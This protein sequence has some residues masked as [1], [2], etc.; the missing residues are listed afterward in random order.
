MHEAGLDNKTSLAFW[1]VN[2]ACH[3]HR[4][5]SDHWHE[6]IASAGSHRS[7]GEST[8]PQNPEARKS[9][10]EKTPEVVMKPGG[11]LLRLV[12]YQSGGGLF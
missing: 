2:V 12:S 5:K 4:T 11:C 6:A 8:P 3:A 1:V 9:P 7:L 10:N